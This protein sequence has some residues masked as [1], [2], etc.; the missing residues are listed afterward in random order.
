MINNYICIELIL[1]EE[2]CIKFCVQSI[3]TSLVCFNVP[4]MNRIFLFQVERISLR[5]DS[6]R[7]HKNARHDKY[8]KK[9]VGRPERKKISWKQRRKLEDDIKINV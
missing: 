3:I 6:L 2:C 4:P 7:I 8:I 1:T 5:I 9:I